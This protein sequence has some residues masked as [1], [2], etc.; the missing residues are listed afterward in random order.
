[1]NS[2][3][4]LEA[5]LNHQRVD[6]VCVDFGSTAV[7]GISASAVSKLRQALTG[8]REYRVKIHEPYQLLG[9]IDVILME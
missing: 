1:M 6:G 2:R 9:E 3:Q 5:A 8:D 4:K 7:T